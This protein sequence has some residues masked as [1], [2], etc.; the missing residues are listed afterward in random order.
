MQIKNQK[1]NRRTLQV[2]NK[3]KIIYIVKEMSCHVLAKV[4]VTKCQI[5]TENTK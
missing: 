5:C 2:R 1:T 3:L 4:I